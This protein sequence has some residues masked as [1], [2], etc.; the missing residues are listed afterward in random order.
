M[1]SQC[2][3][4]GVVIHDSSSWSGA[5]LLAGAILVVVA[6]VLLRATM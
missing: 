5:V 6:Y 1:L 4:D 2:W 3:P